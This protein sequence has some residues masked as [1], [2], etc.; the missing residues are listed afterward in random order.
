MR[1]GNG[2]LL[3]NALVVWGSELGKGNSHSF[4]RAP[5]VTA[6]GCGGAVRTGRFLDLP[7]KTPHNRLLVSMC[8]AMG[9]NDVASFG[10]TDDGQ[11]GL[12]GLGV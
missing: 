4:D 10:A 11:G 12:A 1:E 7:A 6:G 5:F 8:H 3:D 2:T 9:L